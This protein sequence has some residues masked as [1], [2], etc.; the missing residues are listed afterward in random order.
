ME[1]RAV[2]ADIAA[3]LSYQQFK[4]VVFDER[5]VELLLEFQ[6]WPDINRSGRLE[7]DWAI[8]GSGA[9][10]D[11]GTYDAKWKFWPIPLNEVVASGGIIEQNPGH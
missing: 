9:D 3:G 10:G 11:R 1:A 6:F 5:A 4:D 8:L 7:R 2:P